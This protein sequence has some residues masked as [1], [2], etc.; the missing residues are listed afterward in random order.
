[1]ALGKSPPLSRP[2]CSQQ[3][4]GAGC[5]GSPSTPSSQDCFNPVALFTPM[6]LSNPLLT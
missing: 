4:E 1:M 5:L 6:H 3:C 2:H